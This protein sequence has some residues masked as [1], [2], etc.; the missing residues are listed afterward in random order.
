MA[1]E[2]KVLVVTAAATGVALGFLDVVGGRAATEGVSGTM[3]PGGSTLVGLAY[4]LLWLAAVLV[5][6][7]AFLAAAIDRA[8]HYASSWLCS[9]RPSPRSGRRDA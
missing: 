4:L 9:L 7:I 3:P 1:R 8:L 6:P 2:W 5:L